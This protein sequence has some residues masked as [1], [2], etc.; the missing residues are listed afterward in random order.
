LAFLLGLRF[1]RPKGGDGPHS[2]A[3]GKALAE[4]AGS[5]TGKTYHGPTRHMRPQASDIVAGWPGRP[6]TKCRRNRGKTGKKSFFDNG[7]SNVHFFVQSPFD[8]EAS[9][10]VADWRRQRAKNRIMDFVPAGTAFAR[11][12]ALAGR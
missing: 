6:L 8:T 4:V 10:S 2:P 7:C 5:E 3:L 9:A 11:L 12:F 1:K